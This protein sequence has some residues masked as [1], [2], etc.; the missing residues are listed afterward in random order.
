MS[1]RANR[2]RRPL[3][4]RRRSVPGA[5]PGTIAVHPDARSTTVRVIAYDKERVLDRQVEDIGELKEL[6]AKWPQIWVDVEGLADAAAIAQIGSIFSLHPLA[7]EDVVNVHQRAKSE[8]FADH[9]FIVARMVALKEQLESEQI[10]LF[11]G[12][13]FV[14]S[15][16]E[17]APGDSL[18]PVRARIRDNRALV[19][20]HGPDYLAYCILDA[21]LDGYFPV[22]EQLGERL[23]AI[24]DEIM[25]N[26]DARALEHVHV[27][28][29]ELLAL[30]RSIW[31]HRE[32]I[33]ALLRGDCA[34]IT[35]E[36]A[37]YFRDAYDHVTQIID[38]LELY[39]DYAS[40]L[41]DVYLSSVSNRLNE[42]MKVLTIFSTVFIPLS[43]L[44]SIYGMNFDFNDSPWNMPELHS[45]Y[46]YPILLGVMLLI[47]MGLLGYFQRRGW[48]AVLKTRPRQKRTEGKGEAQLEGD[49][50]DHGKKPHPP[51][52][53]T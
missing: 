53:G 41:T 37:L 18:G 47:A 34:L 43:F 12:P 19:R 27:I 5:P 26:P 39:R 30:R 10:S 45:R 8:Q 17:G 2:R 31:P 28:K 22:L 4:P 13:R 42:V 3:V 21:V 23:D 25:S 40:D 14:L 32:A 29:R 9:V 7:L 46:G 15:F 48:L 52:Q 51:H 33:N 44:A 24:E 36:T 11:L 49:R 16:Q 50:A 1:R 35:A 38:L 20:G 6:W